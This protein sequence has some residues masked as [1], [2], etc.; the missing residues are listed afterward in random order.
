MRRSL[1]VPQYDTE[2]HRNKTQAEAEQIIRDARARPGF[3]QANMF[4]EAD[5]EFT[6]VLIFRIG[7]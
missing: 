4:P 1:F 5:G 3:E 7:E 6:V 2:I